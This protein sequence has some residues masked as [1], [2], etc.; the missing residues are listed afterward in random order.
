MPEALGNDDPLMNS[1]L[2]PRASSC[3]QDILSTNSAIEVG[4]GPDTSVS[5]LA[6]RDRR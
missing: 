1:K 4:D 6:A 5:K 2:I 3:D